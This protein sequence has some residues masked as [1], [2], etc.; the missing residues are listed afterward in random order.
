MRSLV[1]GASGFVGSHLVEYLCAQGDDVIG[2][3]HGDGTPLPCSTVP[4]DVTDPRAC[5]R[6]LAEVK[7]D[8]VYHLA[9]IASPPSVTQ[10]VAASLMVN[11]G[12]VHAILSAAAEQTRPPHVL[13]VSSGE[14]YGKAADGAGPI[15]EEISPAPWNEYALSKVMAEEVAHLFQRR[16]RVPV[17][18]ARPF[19]HT[20]PRQADSFVVAAFARQLAAIKANKQSS[21]IRVGNL[22]ARRDFCDVRDVVRAYH[23]LVAQGVTGTFNVA[24]GRAVAIKELL[25]LL[26]R[27]SG[28][29]VVVEQDPAR[30][31]PAEVAEV[32]GSYDK[33]RAA[34]DW[35][36]LVPIEETIDA[37]YQ[38]WE[39]V[40][41][42]G[43]AA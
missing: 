33:L 31:R 20:G 1:T 6:V 2:A 43:A 3:V 30:M 34:T 38:W 25:D 17:V 39:D 9:G 32:I 42:A 10:N 22:A 37:V 19:N 5:R 16:G 7:P 18:V 15:C 4:L 23:L 24:S 21:V 14:V 11:V 27:A 13:I 40:E 8:A 28:L 26:V 35:Y 29:S 36:P 41:R 12:G